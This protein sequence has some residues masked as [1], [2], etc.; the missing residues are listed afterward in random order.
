M[1]QLWF[2]RKWKLPWAPVLVLNLSLLAHALVC[3]CRGPRAKVSV[4]KPP[5]PLQICLPASILNVG[6]C[7]DISFSLPSLWLLVSSERGSR[8]PPEP[9]LWMLPVVGFLTLDA[10]CPKHLS[11]TGVSP[12]LSPAP[13]NQNLSLCL[14]F[15]VH[16]LLRRQCHR[17]WIHQTW[18]SSNHHLSLPWPCFPTWNLGWF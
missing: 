3:T 2:C 7:P 9:C 13:W 1:T 18:F 14:T 6:L 12:S 4:T 11:S 16:S 10:P 15:R 17:S 8:L 5:A